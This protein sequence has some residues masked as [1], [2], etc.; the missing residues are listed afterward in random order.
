RL[1]QRVGHAPQ[2]AEDWQQ[3]DGEANQRNQ[4]GF[5]TR[6][7]GRAFARAHDVV[8]AVGG[9][10]AGRIR[11]TGRIRP[12]RRQLWIGVWRRRCFLV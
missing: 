10:D 7:W 5:D 8:A 1:D 6:T 2:H 3:H 12:F 9:G 4:N 11:R